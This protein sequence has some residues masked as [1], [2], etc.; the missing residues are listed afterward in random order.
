MKIN[1][2]PNL[3]KTIRDIR[4]YKNNS[5]KRK[6]ETYKRNRSLK[7]RAKNG[8][9]SF[10]FVALPVSALGGFGFG[11]YKG[12]DAVI[13]WA[14]NR[15]EQEQIEETVNDISTL[16]SAEIYICEKGEPSKTID[17]E[18]ETNDDYFVIVQSG[19]SLWKITR[20]YFGIKDKDELT[21]L[22]NEIA[23]YNGK[24]GLGQYRQGMDPSLNPS[25]IKSG[26]II[27]IPGC[28]VENYK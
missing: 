15:A 8:I 23:V 5:W 2:S 7:T 6:D 26:Q 27:R 21:Y 4:N 3:E 9:I 24:V 18:S 28:L 25:N 11:V 13:D 1:E 12:I 10:L 20:E 22:V 14:N 17:E 16:V 19:D